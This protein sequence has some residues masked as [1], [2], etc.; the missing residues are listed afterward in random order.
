MPSE[1][2]RSLSC[3]STHVRG[4]L[5]SVWPASLLL[6]QKEASEVFFAS[7]KLFQ[8]KDTNLRRWATQREGARVKGS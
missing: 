6:M 8:N 5:A 7:T 4:S 2:E 1:E 3:A